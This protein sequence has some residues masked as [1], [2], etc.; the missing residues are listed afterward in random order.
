MPSPDG[1]L[2]LSVRVPDDMRE[3]RWDR[4]A[5]SLFPE[6]SRAQL[7]RWIRSGALRLNGEAAKPNEP[8]RPGA[9]LSLDAA[10]PARAPRW[11]PQPIE[12]DVAHEDAALI[13]VD[14]PAGMVVHPGAG[15]AEGTLANALVERYPELAALPRAGLVHRLDKG[16]S[17]LLVVARRDAARRDIAAQFRER[18]A[19]REYLAICA[20]T[21]SGDGAVDAPI[22]RHPVQRQK[23]AV[24]QS[25]RPALTRYRLLRRLSG[26]SY[27]SARLETGRTHQIRVHLAH[28]GHPLLGDPLYGRCRQGAVPM[29]RQALHAAS[30]GLRHPDSGEAL[31]WT[32]PLPADFQALL[33][34]ET[35]N[36]RDADPSTW[37]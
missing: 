29:S 21:L 23:M 18:V 35:L 9:V 28:I 26:A 12:I 14:K 13:V 19:K 6:F 34:A 31:R 3:A 20:G 7:Q 25:G 1:R 33:D 8:A 4:V 22:G 30:L 37:R 36:C 17:G 16:T 24:R 5:A 15:H 2:R 10:A 27:I 11:S 32:S